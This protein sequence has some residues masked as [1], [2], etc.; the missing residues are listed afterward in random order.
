MSLVRINQKSRLELETRV[1]AAALKLSCDKGDSLGA[2]L[3]HQ[4][5]SFLLKNQESRLD[6]QSSSQEPPLTTNRHEH[7]TLQGTDITGGEGIVYGERQTVSPSSGYQ[8]GD[9]ATVPAPADKADA[10]DLGLKQHVLYSLLGVSQI[11]SYDQIHRNFLNLIRKTLRQLEAARRQE[12]QAL[13]ATV[14]RIWIAHDILTDPITRTDY[15]FRDLGLRGNTNQLS[16]DESDDKQ[17]GGQL[18]IGE[19]LQ[20]AGL[21]EST[22]LEIACD[23]HKAMPEVQFGTFLVRQGFIGERDLESV[24]VGQ[25]LLRAGKI[26]VAQFQ[27]AMELCHSRGLAIG[28]TLLEKGYITEAVIENQGQMKEP[29]PPTVFPE[30][31]L[32]NAVPGWKDQLEWNAADSVAAA[33]SEALP[34]P[35]AE[36]EEGKETSSHSTHKGKRGSKSKTGTKS[37]AATGEPEEIEGKA[38][39]TKP[40]EPPDSTGSTEAPESSESKELKDRLDWESEEVMRSTQSGYDTGLFGHIQVASLMFGLHKLE[41]DSELEPEPSSESES[42][43][44]SLP[45]EGRTDD[46][47][48]ESRSKANEG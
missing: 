19:L 25:R 3:A 12:K 10:D 27:V 26:S 46:Q 29:S 40:T 44:V 6:R 15:D 16:L 14:R 20:C 1:L 21:L 2:Q 41:P 37:G 35:S 18:R 5:L 13:L 39:S 17:E 30:L 45:D 31:K 48:D 33:P 8:F 28:E 34:E 7:S 24:L 43:E 9:Q 47:E 42:N 22:E 23:M 38:D 11:S 4:Q 32:T 36:A